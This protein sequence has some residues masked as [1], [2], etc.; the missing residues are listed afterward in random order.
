MKFIIVLIAFF[1]GSNLYSQKY[2]IQEF[3]IK[4]KSKSTVVAHIANQ[5][6]GTLSI[7]TILAY[8]KIELKP[9]RGKIISF[10]TYIRER[11]KISVYKCINANFSPQLM[12]HLQNT[13]AKS[14]N[15]YKISALIDGDTVKLNPIF[16][17][18]G[19]SKSEK[20]EFPVCISTFGKSV[21]MSKISSSNPDKLRNLRG[22]CNG[23]VMELTSF[24]IR[25]Y[26][27]GEE[28]VKTIAGMNDI[29]RAI[30]VVKRLKPGQ[31][32]VFSNMIYKRNDKLM[33]GSPLILKIIK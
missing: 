14:V 1:F 4:P 7:D 29:E 32:I 20:I 30:N 16:L 17:E 6:D 5:F 19:T 26:I 10:E 28:T 27:M 13:K 31:T 33:R 18:L 24:S 21:D 11:A 8:H 22:D 25:Y 3:K 23:K 15:F 12:S 2:S 9:N